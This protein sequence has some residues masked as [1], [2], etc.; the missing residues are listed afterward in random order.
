MGTKT[1]IFFYLYH[2]NFGVLSLFYPYMSKFLGWE[3]DLGHLKTCLTR[4]VKKGLKT[5]IVVGM[6]AEKCCT[7]LTEHL[8][9]L[10]T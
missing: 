1:E 3:I 2:F 7:Q 5:F 9:W 8:R 10:D 6:N 4:A